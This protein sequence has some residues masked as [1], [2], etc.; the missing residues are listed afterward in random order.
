MAKLQKGFTLI[1][2]MIVVAIVGILAAV[3]IPAYQD[4]TVRAQVTEGLNIAADAKAAY[5]DFITNRGRLPVPVGANA[6][7]SLGLAIPTSLQ[8]NYTASVTANADGSVDIVFGNRA[9]NNITLAGSNTL[10]LRVAVDQMPAP[11]TNVAWVCGN[12]GNPNA[13]QAAIG[14]NST[15]LDP[16]YLPGDCRN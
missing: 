14:A 7:A 3:A 8:G 2:L 16:K 9:N 4:Y 1:E 12:G 5:S 15:D 10:T 11:T 13:N 6:N